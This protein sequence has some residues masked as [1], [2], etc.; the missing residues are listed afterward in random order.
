MTI[1][2]KKLLKILAY[3]IAAVFIVDVLAIIFH[4]YYSF[5][6]F[7]MIMHFSGGVWLGLAAM[8]Y[9]SRRNPASFGLSTTTVLQILG[10]VI[11]FGGGWEVFE[12]L[13][14]YFVVHDFSRFD[15]LDTLSDLVCDTSGGIFAMGLLAIIMPTK[16]DTV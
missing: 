13:T 7:D 14:D 4:W 6:Y 5:W 16:K 12:A 2:R 1:D 15:V 11:L 9:L 8:W 10:I 3:L